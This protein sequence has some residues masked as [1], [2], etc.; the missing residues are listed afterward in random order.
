MRSLLLAILLLSVWNLAGCM[1]KRAVV[2]PDSRQ[3][4]CLAEGQ[5]PC[6]R[7]VIDAGFLREIMIKL[8]DCKK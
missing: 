3:L 1:T 7:Y 4:T 8:E 2:L 6:E 5:V